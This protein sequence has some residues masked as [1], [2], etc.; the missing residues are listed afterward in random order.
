[1]FRRELEERE[2]SETNALDVNICKIHHSPKKQLKTFD[3]QVS[4][5][6]Q[7]VSTRQFVPSKS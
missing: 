2:D 5:L 4:Q 3:I 1:M 7:I 6:T